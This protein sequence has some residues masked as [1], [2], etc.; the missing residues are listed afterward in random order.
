MQGNPSL[1]LVA[2]IAMAFM[3]HGAYAAT[4]LT[5]ATEYPATSMPGQGVSTFAELVRAKTS[6]AVVIDASFDAA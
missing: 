1:R 3:A 4:T 6:G 2:G 5:M